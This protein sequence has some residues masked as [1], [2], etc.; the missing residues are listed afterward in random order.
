MTFFRTISLEQLLKKAHDLRGRR[1][2]TRIQSLIPIVFGFPLKRSKKS[3]TFFQANT[4]N[5]SSNGLIME[6]ISPSDDIT[7]KLNTKNQKIILKIEIPERARLIRVEGTVSRV[8][9]EKGE[10]HIKYLAAIRF[11]KIE[12]DERIM[13]IA[14]AL[15]LSRKRTILKAGIILLALGILTTTVWAVQ[16]QHAESSAADKLQYSEKLRLALKKNIDELAIIKKG[17][18]EDLVENEQ[19]LEEQ[20]SFLSEKEEEILNKEK[21]IIKKQNQFAE[22]ESTVKEKEVEL[23][24]KQEKLLEIE[25]K[26][27]NASHDLDQLTNLALK[28]KAQ[29]QVLENKMYKYMVNAKVEQILLKNSADIKVLMDPNYKKAKQAYDKQSYDKAAGYFKKIAKKHPK[30]SLGYSGLTRALYKANR[31]TE[32]KQAFQEFLK[33]LEE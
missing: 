33:F 14:Y 6:L 17:L 15:R 1:G 27:E 30:S 2:Y 12:L 7:K 32:S 18:E 29:L 13:L 21:D 10:N 5:I 8:Q 22:M 3:P 25:V 31:E 26:W 9:P 24:K 16:S 19:K 4:I 28:K 11:D 23:E 20:K